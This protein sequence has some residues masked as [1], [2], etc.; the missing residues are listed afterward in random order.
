[1]YGA[2]MIL[3][4]IHSF[5]KAG[6]LIGFGP[7]VHCILLGTDQPRSEDCKT[8]RYVFSQN[9]L[10]DNYQFYDYINFITF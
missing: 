9:R 7:A 1:M 2:M 10:Q 8:D 5:S 6:I 4:C 3:K